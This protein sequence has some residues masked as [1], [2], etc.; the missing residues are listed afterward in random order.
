MSARQKICYPK[1]YL[2]GNEEELKYIS[3]SEWACPKD[4]ARIERFLAK[5]KKR[6]TRY[7]SA[8]AFA[9]AHKLNFEEENGK[10]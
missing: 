6:K 10:R 7:T 3:L 5:L 2:C 4:Y 9:G 8:V 1:C